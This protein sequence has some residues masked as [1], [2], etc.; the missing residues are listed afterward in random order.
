ML[1]FA[2][3]EQSWAGSRFLA[4]CLPWPDARADHIMST[5][6]IS[7]TT[8]CPIA[9]KSSRLHWLSFHRI[10]ISILER[11]AILGRKSF[12]SVPYTCLLT[13]P[14]LTLMEMLSGLSPCHS[15]SVV[16]TGHTCRNPGFPPLATLALPHP[17]S[18]FLWQ[19]LAVLD[20]QKGWTGEFPWTKSKHLHINIYSK[21]LD[22]K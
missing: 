14:N 11:W 22:C 18:S 10:Q 5:L 19:Y 17:F 8:N 7:L 4:L 2:C 6:P 12:S 20:L 1:L 9:W 16:V 3:D 15:D 13:A 21:S